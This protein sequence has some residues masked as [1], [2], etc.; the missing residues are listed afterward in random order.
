M[1]D[2]ATASP[3]RSLKSG[4]S[5]SGARTTDVTAAS[6]TLS[7][8]SG[9]SPS[10]ADVTDVA[11][12]SSTLSADFGKSSSGA[13]GSEDTAASSV[14]LLDRPELGRAR[15]TASTAN[16]GHGSAE[17]RVA[18]TVRG[19]AMLAGPIA[20]S[21]VA[22]LTSQSV[23]L[24][25]L[26]RM[27]VGALY[28]RSLYS[29]VALLFTALTQGIAVT[30]QVGVARS[31]GRGR[32]QDVPG[33]L[34]SLARLGLAIYAVVGAALVAGTPLLATFLGAAHGS[35]GEFRGFLAAMALA[36]MAT[37]LGELGAASLRGRGAPA[38]ATISTLTSITC[39]IGG[40]YVLG[41]RLGLG[42]MAVP[43]A[44]ALG[45]GAQIALDVVWL[46]RLGLLA[47]PRALG[48]WVSGTPRRLAAIGAP[49][50]ASFV[51]LFLVNSLLLR[52]MAPFGERA[53]AGFNLGY[54]VQNMVILPAVGLGSA[55]AITMN[56]WRAAGRP[57]VAE[58]ALRRGVVL[59][60]GSYLPAGAAVF[61][62]RGPLART[63]AADP[64]VA[65][66]IERFL[67][68]VGP[69]F[70]CT[71]LVLAVF[72]V[73]E[74]TG[75]GPI[76]AGMNAFYFA[77]I[78][79][80]G[81]VLTARAHDPGM[82]YRTI[83]V[84]ALTGPVT[85]FPLAWRLLRRSAAERPSAA[86]TEPDGEWTAREYG[87]CDRDL[88]LSWYEDPDFRYRA[89]QPNLLSEA[90]IDALLSE[91][92][93][94]LLVG[95]VPVGLYAVEP[96]GDASDTH[97]L[98]R[99]RLRAGLS[100]VAWWVRA[101]DEVTATLSARLDLQRLTLLL[102]EDDHVPLDAA[103]AA[104]FHHEGAL[105]GLA[106]RGGARLAVAHLALLRPHAAA[107]RAPQPTGGGR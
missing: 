19:I 88:V 63:L 52:V 55:I 84:A 62:A 49:V 99:L 86:S 56:Q 83:A 2:V 95:G 70:A 72:T 37:F 58:R 24:A 35:V 17:P 93:Q 15:S 57:D 101:Y 10:I 38:F 5:L 92:D 105:P 53:V 29:P 50:S 67:G 71:G 13:G 48:R 89:E 73:L 107:G 94:V 91:W 100:D 43:A 7:T 41:F 31:V 42:L 69:T 1:T 106:V 98:L 8:D 76:A 80:I 22:L 9:T 26:G 14:R 65:A 34:G 82:L 32:L 6:P 74:Q 33:Q 51:V 78:V 61:L 36:T 47:A 25:M 21:T 104:G 46:R 68:V 64:A 27:G 60:L 4:T 12:A 81:S 79:V 11:T 18:P 59:V 20:L 90:E 16:A 97:Y 87:P 40:V 28:V 3:T 30:V 102:V 75:Y 44:V 23:V 66:Q 54:T 39:V 45:G 77:S 85:A 96:H 103:R